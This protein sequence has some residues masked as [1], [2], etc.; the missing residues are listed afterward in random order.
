[1]RNPNRYNCD[2]AMELPVS[3]KYHFCSMVLAD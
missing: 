2:K 3:S 1:M